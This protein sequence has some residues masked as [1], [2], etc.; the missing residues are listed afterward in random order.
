MA[1]LVYDCIEVEGCDE[2]QPP[3]LFLHGMFGCKEQWE[4]VPRKVG[5]ATK[6]KVYAIDARNHGA[7]EWTDDFDFDM[8]VDDL[9]HFMDT[10]GAQKAT[11]VG[12][13]MG[14]ITAIKAALR[15]PERIEKFAAE[16]I[17]VRK[18]S[19]EILN[20]IQAYVSLA[21]QALEHMP[22]S[23]DDE[24]E[25]KKFIFQ[26]VF[27]NLPPEVQKLGKK[28]DKNDPSTINK[29]VRLRRTEDG[30]FGYM[31]NA[32]VLGRAV[33]DADRIMSEP[34]GVYEGPA[35]FIYGKI[36]P[37][38]INQEEENIKKYFPNAELVGI[39]NATHSVH[40]DNP[41]EYLDAL[42]KFL[43]NAD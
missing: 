13:S 1:K 12:H 3:I 37:F 30:R 27:Q 8:N 33:G 42:L 29:S 22:D 31:Y 16:D 5:E 34:Q 20:T 24:D 43:Q 21:Q 26:Y 39:E 6:R 9:F 41:E 2:D 40:N 23:V 4:E 18:V 38:L 7:S 36:S 19:Q 35:C 15:E 17:G 10:I 32:Q 14:G 25:A 28:F 11:I